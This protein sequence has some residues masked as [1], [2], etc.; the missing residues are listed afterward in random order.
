MANQD[1]VKEILLKFKSSGSDQVKK[2]AESISKSFNPRETDKFLKS[3]DQINQK[4]S[5]AGTGMS[6]EM[7]KVTD[8]FKEL[9]NQHFQKAEKNLDRIGKLL[10]SQIQNIDK[11]KR[12]GA[13]ADVIAQRSATM[14]RTA[15][16]FDTM[17]SNTIAPQRGGIGGALDRAGGGGRFGM[18]TGAMGVVGSIAGGVGTISSM[19][20][21]Y[22]MQEMANRSTVA[23]RF[24]QQ[25]FDVFS[26]NLEKATLYSDPKRASQIKATTGN[27]NKY[28]DRISLSGI[29]GGAA[30]VLGGLGVGAGALGAAALAT[31]PAWAPL[32]IGGGMIAAGAGGLYQ[33]AKYF[34]GGGREAAK[35]QNL[36][37]AESGAAA[38]T[39]DPEY[40]KFLQQN[41]GSR[42]QYQRSLQMGDNSALGFRQ[43]MRSAGIVDEGQ[44]A[45]LGMQFRQFGNNVAPGLGIAAATQARAYGQ[46]SSTTANIMSKIATS[47]VGGA[48]AAA[49]DLSKMFTNAV[50]SGINDSALIEEYQKQS[51][52]ILDVFKGRLSGDQ[53]SGVLS[54]F[55]AGGD[56]RNIGTARSAM[57]SFGGTMAGTTSLMQMKKTAKLM[58]VAG[59]DYTTFQMLNAM[60]GEQIAAMTPEAMKSMG[61]GEDQVG[62]MQDLQK[63][64]VE[65]TFR[66]ATN[67]SSVDKIFSSASKNKKMTQLDQS[68][69]YT[70]LTGKNAF[71]AD[72]AEVQ[73]V[74]KKAMDVTGRNYEGVEFEGAGST[75]TLGLSQTMT[76]ADVLGGIKGKEG[77]AA[78]IIDTKA[79]GQGML[80]SSSA[81]MA[82][83]NIGSILQVFQE[84]AKKVQEGLDSNAL[85]GSIGNISA[86]ADEIANAMIRAANK[87]DGGSRGGFSSSKEEASSAKPGER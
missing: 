71:D 67:K 2:V 22:T 66:T 60:S 70:V 68:K 53:A 8:Y 46:D 72:P 54:S 14:R 10:N 56:V 21:D 38:Q 85:G 78:K 80:D 51:S 4:F 48:K 65:E 58:D 15:S 74:I 69:L 11:L 77:V 34:M 47:N 35:V 45:Q 87:I 23:N 39:L 73:N 9:N 18:F 20:K 82:S 36:Q 40:M 59:G 27:L 55:M 76:E 63:T 32:A 6:T 62:K 64:Q 57:A 24:K 79:A 44:M 29:I 61:F 28:S 3:I 5:K 50:K 33:G 84:S 75:K 81:E 19:Q 17:Q 16:A 13:S 12:E 52:T 83:K 1:I 49:A 30:G 86:A 25:A 37:A 43:G 7:K 42:M 41:A 26:G 31:A